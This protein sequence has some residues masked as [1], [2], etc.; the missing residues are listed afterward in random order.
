VALK[1]EVLLAQEVQPALEEASVLAFEAAE[2]AWLAHRLPPRILEAGGTAL[3]HARPGAEP[4]A[5][6]PL[7]WI[8]AGAPECCSSIAAVA[9]PTGCDKASRRGRAFRSKVRSANAAKVMH[10]APAE[11]VA[12]C[13]HGLAAVQSE[14]QELQP[15]GQ[16]PPFSAE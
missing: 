5:L 16:P 8:G 3:V 7:L 9:A 4:A 11:V 13:Q 6:H 2:V 1:L 10:T 12:C 15:A 14:Y